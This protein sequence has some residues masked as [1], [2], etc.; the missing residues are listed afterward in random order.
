MPKT[1]NTIPTTT[2][3][4]VYTA[5][6]HNNIVTNVNNY[7]VP[8]MCRVRRSGTASSAITP[9]GSTTGFLEWNTQDVDTEDDEMWTSGSATRITVRTAGFYLVNVNFVLDFTGTSTIQQSALVHTTSGGSETRIAAVYYAYSQLGVLV[10]TMTST[11]S[12]AVGDYFR[13][14]VEAVTGGSSITLRADPTCVF[15]AAWLGQVS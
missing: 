6:A 1:Y 13:V 11:F 5:A 15:S 12:A 14:R 9:S 7:R 3:G 10:H 4:S 8:P 2:T